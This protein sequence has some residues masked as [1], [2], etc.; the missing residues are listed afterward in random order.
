MKNEGSTAG[1]PER[2]GLSREAVKY[3]A[4]FLMTLNHISYVF[5]YGKHVGHDM[6]ALFLVG[7]GCFT[8][9]VM[10][11][12]MVDGIYYTRS[13]GRYA[14]RLA[15]FSVISQLPYMFAFSEPGRLEYNNLNFIVTLLICLLMLWAFRAADENENINK[16][17]KTLIYIA[18]FAAA[19]YLSGF[20]D[21]ARE[22][23]V[24][25]AEFFFARRLLKNIDLGW[26]FVLITHI[27]FS[28][29]KVVNAG[30]LD[31]NGL[32]FVLMVSIG[33]LLAAI[34]VCAFYKGGRSKHKSG[35]SKWFFYIYYPAHLA[36]LGAIKT[37]VLR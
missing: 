31:L 25:A 21:W 36:L 1:A 12:F 13:M 15:V 4:L 9:P 33:P 17:V 20:C 26:I 19:Y 27:T 24:F 35:F 16:A 18:A 3:I 2:G 37:L 8:A 34:T 6:L 29:G 28:F 23:P 5:L 30:A 11:Y 10:L 14:L 32:T 7:I 22:A